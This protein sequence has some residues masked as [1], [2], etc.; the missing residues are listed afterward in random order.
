[1]PFQLDNVRALQI[2]QVLRQGAIILISILLAKSSLST[3][4]IGVYEILM[5]I[6]TTV[7]FFWING[8]IQG[9]LPYFPELKNEERQQFIF[10][11]SFVFTAI[12]FFVFVLL[13]LFEKTI[14]ISLAGQPIIPFYRIF[15]LQI[16]FLL[17]SFLIEYFYLLYDQ[18]KSILQFGVFAFCAQIL[19]I[20]VSLFFGKGLLW[21]FNGLLILSILRFVWLLFIIKKYGKV[22]W[23]FHALHPYWQVAIPLIGYALITGFPPVFDNWL[24]GY[25]FQDTSSFAIFRYGARELPL[26]IAL[27]NSLSAAMVPAIHKDQ[28]AAFKTLHQRSLRLYHLLFPL[29]IILILTS[30]FWFPKVFNNEFAESAEIFNVFLLVVVSRL[31][32]PQTVLLALKETRVIF[33]I[34]IIELLLNIILSIF[35]VQEF[36]LVGIAFGT[37]IAYWFEKIAIAFYLHYKHGIGLG[38]YT[39]VVWFFGYSILLLLSYLL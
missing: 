1:M 36:G 25:F 13:F 23:N 14:A 6:G 12:S 4:E 15:I 2:F 9:M 34:S 37:V 17:P 22:S 8:M 38:A 7:S 24:V 20:I 5:F 26:A 11:I 18:P 19:I 33:G 39:P 3:D 16:F 10:K 28:A 35:L 31:V 32:F 27:A 21:I 29:S 30:E